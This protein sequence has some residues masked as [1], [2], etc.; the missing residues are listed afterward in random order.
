MHHLIVFQDDSSGAFYGYRVSGNDV[1]KRFPT[2]ARRIEQ[3]VGIPLSEC[4]Q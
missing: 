4:K 3:I 2:I 1:A